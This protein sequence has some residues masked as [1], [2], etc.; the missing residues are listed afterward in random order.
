MSLLNKLQRG[1]PRCL[2]RFPKCWGICCCLLLCA[3]ATGSAHHTLDERSLD[4]DLDAVA[5]ECMEILNI[6]QRTDLESVSEN[7]LVRQMQE[8]AA[9]EALCSEALTRAYQG[10]GGSTMAVHLGRT[11]SLHSLHAELALS[12]RFDNL[13]GYCNILEDVI[14]HLVEDMGLLEERLRDFS[15]PDDNDW[16]HL[17]PLYE[18]SRQTLELSVIDRHL[19]CEY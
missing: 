9:N 12:Q 17:A 13:S 2:Q 14:E 18:L 6:Y 16:Q 10:P 15:S 8:S 4:Y 3:C 19:H 1:A 11:I 5:S 7:E